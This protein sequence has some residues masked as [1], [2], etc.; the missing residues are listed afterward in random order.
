M[1]EALINEA[2]KAF[3]KQVSDQVARITSEL[4]RMEQ[5]LSAGMVDQ[6]VLT[7][8]RDAVNR[9]RSTGWQVQNWLEGD[10][11]TLQ[12][13]LTEERIRVTTRLATH[14]AAE[15]SA[16]LMQF[17]PK[18]KNQSLILPVHFPKLDSQSNAV[19][20]SSLPRAKRSRLRTETSSTTLVFP[21]KIKSARILPVAGECITPC[22]LK[23]LARKSPGTS[24][25]GPRMQ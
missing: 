4:N 8:F 15:L 7:E 25:T 9:V 1:T 19:S 24:G 13:M 23:P 14:L 20:C 12:V 6:R 11:Q 21:V 17:C 5:L 22:P 2:D 10:P 18:H 16:S 3:N